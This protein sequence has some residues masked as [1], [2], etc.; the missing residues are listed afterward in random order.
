M[1]FKGTKCIQINQKEYDDIRFI[2]SIANCQADAVS[3]II[4]Y[5]NKNKPFQDMPRYMVKEFAY[6]LY[7]AV[8]NSYKY[9]K[10]VD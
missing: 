1:K 9:M 10:I 5:L 7:M 2:Q 4:D 3:K 8:D 6:N